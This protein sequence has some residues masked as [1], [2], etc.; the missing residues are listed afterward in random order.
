MWGTGSNLYTQGATGF[1]LLSGTSTPTNLAADNFAGLSSANC[2]TYV[3]AIYATH[4]GSYG[5]FNITNGTNYNGSTFNFV[6]FLI[7]GTNNVNVSD[8]NASGF[9]SI[10]ANTYGIGFEIDNTTNGANTIFNNITANGNDIG[11]KFSGSTL[12]NI[13]NIVAN[14]NTTVGLHLTNGSIIDNAN[15]VTANYNGQLNNSSTYGMYIDSGS[16]I[17]QGTD[18]ALIGNGNQIVV[19]GT[20]SYAN[21]IN[22][23]IDA[24]ATDLSAVLVSAGGTLIIKNPNTLV[25]Q[26]ILQLGS[27]LAV[28]SNRVNDVP[29]Q[30]GGIQ[31]TY[32]C[33]IRGGT[34]GPCSQ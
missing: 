26:V 17:M 8:I 2:G 23:D 7:S 10:N 21:L 4:P 5:G 19:S 14:N 3:C 33:D 12:D 20:N 11:L 16:Q 13:S 30:G 31:N 9:T 6:G 25:G 24:T 34:G 18:F 32:T 22:A 29:N 28:T 27:T 15:T 1:L